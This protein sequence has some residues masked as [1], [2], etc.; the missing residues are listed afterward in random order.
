MSLIIFGATEFLPGDAASVVLGQQATPENLENLRHRMGLDRPAYVRYLAWIFGWT[1]DEGATFRSKDGGKK[2]DRLAVS[3]ITPISRL[4][5]D[6]PSEGWA[7]T[8]RRIYHTT[9]G[10]VRWARQLRSDR[11]LKAIEF[12]DEMNGLALAEGGII[13]RTIE[14]GEF[15]EQEKI[16]AGYM[17]ATYTSCEDEENST[18]N[19]VESGT[20]SELSDIVFRDDGHAWIVGEKG[21]VLRSEDGGETWASIDTGIDANLLS[22]AFANAQYGVAVGERGAILATSDGGRTWLPADGNTNSRLNAVDFADASTVWAVG[23]SGTVLHSA[24][25]GLTW[26]RREVSPP[27]RNALN[28][29]AFG[30]VNGVIVGRR[31][32][33]ADNRRRRSVLDR[34]RGARGRGGND[35]PGD[36]RDDKAVERPRRS[37]DRRGRD[38]RVGRLGRYGLGVGLAG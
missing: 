37:S 13:Y 36:V 24:D 10:G 20:S 6:S 5:F 23:E 14:G 29:V 8:G 38:H 28:A 33:R 7:V 25:A 17:Q 9:D 35:T 27:T 1:D 15:L 26:T 32:Y 18:W 16:C 12:A 31:R 3:T 22:V 30:G 19:R 2:W 34:Q 21:T 11:P 4:T